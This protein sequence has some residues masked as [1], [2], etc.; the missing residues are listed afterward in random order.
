M[1]EGMESN[2][3]T[4]ALALEVIRLPESLG[5]LIDKPNCLEHLGNIY[6]KPS[7]ALHLEFTGGQAARE[8]RHKTR[9]EN[10]KRKI[11]R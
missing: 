11:W 10:K 5:N 8:R 1:L 6:A 3:R 7:A 9:N 4:A 2:S